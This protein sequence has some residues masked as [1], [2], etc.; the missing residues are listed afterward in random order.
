MSQS[1]STPS[2][3]AMIPL[4]MDELHHL[5]N[6][7]S[8]ESAQ[9]QTEC[10]HRIETPR[11]RPSKIP[12]PGTKG[13]LAP[14]PPT[15]RNSITQRSPS[16]PPSNR[17]LSKSTGSLIGRSGPSSEKKDNNS[18]SMNRPESAQSLR[19]DSSLSSRSSSI[20][21][22]SK[23]PS[24]RLQHNSPIS[25]PKRESFA[26]KARNMDSLTL[27]QQSTVSSPQNS[28]PSSSTTNLYKSSS[29]KDLSS[30]FSTG[31]NRDRKQP[32]VSVRR[33]SSATVGRTG[34]D[35]TQSSEPDNGKVPNLR[36]R[37]WN[38]LKI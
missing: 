17:S 13:Y 10:D 20:P 12:L 24:S 8:T 22:S 33:V 26:S 31:Q 11:K 19:K 28:T 7:S 34:I 32:A 5:H 2:M 35:I 3:K 18:P 30:S 29:K 14:K 1:V 27:L 25:K 36:T 37:L 15:G 4:A 38:M 16:G 9:D 21:I 6:S 23:T